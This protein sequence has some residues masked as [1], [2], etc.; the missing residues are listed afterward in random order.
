VA[1]PPKLPICWPFPA[2]R[3]GPPARW[4]VSPPGTCLSGGWMT[5]RPAGLSVAPI[6]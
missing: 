4:T 5:D 6:W 2:A 1:N 3:P